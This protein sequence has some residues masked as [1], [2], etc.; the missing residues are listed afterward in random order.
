MKD[1]TICAVI[2]IFM[3]CVILTTGKKV[4]ITRLECINGQNRAS[5]TP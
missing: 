3:C 1:I 5:T 4:I 2:V